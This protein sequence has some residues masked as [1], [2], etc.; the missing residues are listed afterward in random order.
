MTSQGNERVRSADHTRGRGVRLSLAFALAL[1]ASARLCAQEYIV[2]EET[3]RPG[4]VNGWSAPAKFLTLAASGGSGHAGALHGQFSRQVFPF[5]EADAFTAT[6][7]ASTGKFA[8]DYFAAGK[9]VPLWMGFD[10][11]AENVLPSSCL[12]RLTGG[13]GATNT[14]FR[15]VLPQLAATNAWT[16]ITVPLGG[17]SGWNGGTAAQFSNVLE[18]VTSVQ[19]R[20]TR[21]GE[22]EQSYQLDNF[23]VV[24]RIVDALTDSDGD[25]LPD[26]YER[27]HTGSATAM[28]P[29][30]DD[31]HDGVPNIQE[32]EAGT[33]P[34]AT[35][36]IL[37][38]LAYAQP[39]G[40][41]AQMSLQTFEG[42][43]YQIER[44]SDLSAQPPVWEPVGA[45][46]PG[47]GTRMTLSG[48]DTSSAARFYRI[49]VAR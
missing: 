37:K 26:D 30:G 21:S 33:D 35:D 43:T 28:L 4:G 14:F 8:C 45:P 22:N 47:D 2:M 49:R 10:V 17:V 32:Y 5:P 24:W 42:R 39:S 9:R 25:G 7:G 41:A 13:V 44:T 27:A 31:D 18:N 15:S 29:G 34:L 11:R 20:V 38:I 6:S 16:W 23:T 40:G 36:S 19:L 48:G 12:L 3:W 1:A 46:V